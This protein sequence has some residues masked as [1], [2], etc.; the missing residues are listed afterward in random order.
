MMKQ[1]LL[2]VAGVL[3]ILACG[4]CFLPP[5]GQKQPTAPP[6]NPKLTGIH[7]IRVEVAETVDP[8]HLDIIELARSTASDIS[9]EASGRGIKALTSEGRVDATLSIVIT[10][11]SAFQ[12]RMNDINGAVNWRYDVIWDATLTTSDGNIRWQEKNRRVRF[13]HWF[14]QPPG[15]NVWIDHAVRAEA[16]NQFRVQFV[17]DFLYG[18]R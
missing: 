8:G 12:T 7:K 11:E 5:I 4:A 16:V 14:S 15:E 1:K 3:G 10:D 2:T 18:A 13:S 17:P 9:A 6:I